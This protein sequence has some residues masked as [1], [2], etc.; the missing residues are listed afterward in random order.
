M[1]LPA[2]ERNNRVVVV[3]AVAKQIAVAIA[4]PRLLCRPGRTREMLMWGLLVHGIWDVKLGFH[5]LI[6]TKFVT[7]WIFL[8]EKWWTV[9][10]VEA[11]TSRFFESLCQLFCHSSSQ[12]F[13][14]NFWGLEEATTTL[15]TMEIRTPSDA[16]PGTSEAEDEDEEVAATSLATGSVLLPHEDQSA[17]RPHEQMLQ[18]EFSRS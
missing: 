13:S 18:E 10:Q 3:V 9:I 12:H 15:A 11:Q 6:L 8:D 14:C 17:R 4:M 1:V 7:T 2:V 16:S 5:P